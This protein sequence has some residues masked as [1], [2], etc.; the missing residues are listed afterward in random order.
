[1]IRG[2]VAKRAE[3]ILTKKELQSRENRSGDLAK[4][5]VG[6]K[7]K[8]NLIHLIMG[9]GISAQ[10]KS[11]YKLEFKARGRDS[12]TLL[13]VGK[14]VLA[15]RAQS[16]Q[17]KKNIEWGFQKTQ[18]NGQQNMLGGTV[19]LNKTGLANEGEHWYGS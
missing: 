15:K 3:W 9:C 6:G 8:K 19:T 17:S 4:R 7:K 13:Q 18:G 1:M 10:E 5:R 12:L 11:A 16:R 2:G 14:R